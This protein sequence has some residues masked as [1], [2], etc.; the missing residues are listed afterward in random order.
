MSSFSCVSP[1]ADR[2]K[3]TF[4]VYPS[5]YTAIHAPSEPALCDKVC[6]DGYRNISTLRRN[7]LME[8]QNVK[9]WNKN[10]VL[11]IIINFLVFMNHL[12][13]LSTFPFYIE[14]LGG[15]EAIAGFAA[16]LFSIIAVICRP[17]IDRKSVV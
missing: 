8:G 9:L 4:F 2:G 14:Y 3:A 15:S 7:L 13:I 1:I 12:M 17:F 6:P 16:A 11:I 10:F 5:G